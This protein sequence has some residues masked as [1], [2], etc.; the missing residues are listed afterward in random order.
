MQSRLCNMPLQ[1]E[2]GA[3]STRWC[4]AYVEE[5]FQHPDSL[6]D[7]EE[8][9]GEKIDGVECFRYRGKVGVGTEWRTDIEL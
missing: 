1:G 2:D 6:V 8:L 9:S 5:V 7:V 4:A 3:T